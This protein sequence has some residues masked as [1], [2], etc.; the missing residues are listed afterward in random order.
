[1]YKDTIFAKCSLHVSK[2]RRFVASTSIGKIPSDVQHKPCLAV[3]GNA[4]CY[5]KLGLSVILIVS[6]PHLSRT[7]TFHSRSPGHAAGR[8]ELKTITTDERKVFYQVSSLFVPCS[9]VPAPP[10]DLEFGRG[11]F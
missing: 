11:K 7:R 4:W 8:E 1:M 10:F 5:P 6:F 2:F 3:N 9:G